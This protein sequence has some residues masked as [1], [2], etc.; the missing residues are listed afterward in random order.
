MGNNILLQKASLYGGA[1]LFTI[2]SV[3]HRFRITKYTPIL[4]IVPFFL[5]TLV[6]FAG[7]KWMDASFEDRGVYE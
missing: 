7:Y 5:Q 4:I 6:K 1:I 3:K 2:Y